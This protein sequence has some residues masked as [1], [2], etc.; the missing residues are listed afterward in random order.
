[1]TT[2]P[3]TTATTFAIASAAALLLAA[4]GQFCPRASAATQP[5]EPT[6][7][8]AAYL[9]ISVRDAAATALGGAGGRAD[10]VVVSW[11]APGPLAGTGFGSGAGLRR[12]DV[13]VAINGV[14]IGSSAE[15]RAAVDGLR[16]GEQVVLTVRRPPRA[17]P[18]AAVV[19]VPPPG[20]GDEMLRITTVAAKRDEWTGTIGRGLRE[21]ASI[22]PAAEGEFEATILGLAQQLGVR[23][24]AP[25]APGLD[26][27]LE[28][29]ASVQDSNL[30]ENALAPVVHALRRPLSIDAAERP[31]AEAARAAAGGDYEKIAALIGLVLGV[32]P[33][34]DPA[35]QD[36]EPPDW[37]RS[38]AVALAR[39]LRDSVSIEDARATD[40]LAVIRGSA[41]VAGVLLPEH[42]ARLRNLEALR[43][44]L[45]AQAGPE[46]LADVPAAL[47]RLVSGDVLAFEANPDG[48][49][50]VVGGLGENV[51][52]MIGLRVV[53]DAGGNDSYLF[54]AG[55]AITS[56]H[57]IFDAGGDDR[58]D[59][60]G[61]FAGPGAGIFA[62]SV[63]DDAAG[64][65]T[66]RSA[67][68]GGL[69]TGLFGIGIIIDRAGNDVYDNTGASA[70]GAAVDVGWS[71]GAGLYGAGLIIDMGGADVYRGQKLCQGVGG[72][73]GLG[74]II[75]RDGAD[76]YRANGP[77][78]PSAYGTPAVYLGM[79]Q[80]FG[81]GVR[82]YAAGGVG[83]IWDLGGNDRYEAGE[84][85]QGGGYYFGLGI[86]HDFGGSDL[87]YANRYG[88]AFA[89]HQA[90][91]LLIDDAGD[92]TY[93]S[94]T[95]A[96]QGGA[97]DE[98][99]A[100]LIDR[101]GNDSYR[102]DGLGQGAAA[103][104]AI[105]VLLDLGGADRYA[106]ADPLTA[107]T[108]GASGSNEYHWR[109][110]RVLSFSALIDR[111]G[112]HDAYPPGRSNGEKRWTGS[113]KPEDQ[114]RAGLW[115]IF[116]DE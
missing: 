103:Q 6:G 52:D 72:P 109:E 79:S 10:G 68:V 31:L 47:R 69:A 112:G 24:G 51:Y 70:T 90:A 42:L 95:A 92:D 40:H 15:F 9:G 34:A 84:F 20:E 114:T 100:M 2:R 57:I 4:A 60:G 110:K 27:L 77:A 61:H 87:Y 98:S 55:P 18:D 64:N 54:S 16:P 113:V 7:R 48:T 86:L 17:N 53:Y 39:R 108:L 35:P 83:A 38:A 28:H 66:Y 89:A 101:A 56:G 65:D 19:D 91:G 33:A 105:A 81:Y 73:R 74:A 32:E 80:G 3:R 12:G 76:L 25:D 29:L 62:L 75:D 1:M 26:A 41:G 44:S 85:S 104:Q 94:M 78:Y 63:I 82:G 67:G 107:A 5:D 88:Q 102:C 71:I 59:A 58:Y 43:R 37:Y 111:G 14:S 106:A 96:S 50:N 49:F 116:V 97:W 22:G 13:I 23:K 93:W 21:G 115:G 99:V 8:G 45:A 46:P 36:W 30:D 11:I